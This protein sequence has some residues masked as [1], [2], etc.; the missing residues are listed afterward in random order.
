MDKKSYLLT[1]III[2]IVGIALIVMHSQIDVIRWIVI[3]IGCAL[4]IPAVFN[5]IW[6]LLRRRRTGSDIREAN[7]GSSIAV[8][9][10]TGLLGIWIVCMPDF[11]AAFIV[12]LFAALLVFLAII[13]VVLMIKA[14][15]PVRPPFWFY[16]VPI[17]MIIVAILLL[18]SPLGSINATIVLVT[19]IAMTAS[20]L[21]RLVELATV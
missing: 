10:I 19:G 5:L 13:D 1:P 21:N 15:S 6:I 7:D 11:F 2:L 12:Y 4:L 18:A 14:S 20:G 9:I 16:I 8:S 17:A 3:L